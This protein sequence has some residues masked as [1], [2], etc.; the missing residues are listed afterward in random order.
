MN[1]QVL[2][3]L[4]L[5][6][7]ILRQSGK[8]SAATGAGGAEIQV[9][10][11]TNLLT[12]I[13]YRIGLPDLAAFS[14]LTPAEV[15]V[16]EDP[17]SRYIQMDDNDSRNTRYAK[18]GD[19]YLNG[20]WYFEVSEK[21]G[22]YRIRG[23]GDPSLVISMSPKEIKPDAEV[24]ADY[25]LTYGKDTGKN[26]SLW[27][28]IPSDNGLIYQLLNYGLPGLAK[29]TTRIGTF[30]RW[31]G[32]QSLTNNSLSADPLLDPTFFRFTLQAVDL[33]KSDFY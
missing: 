32:A 25:Y 2:F 15:T 28:I 7:V 13:H 17:S 10:P 29:T 21:V 5:T 12:G 11:G 1:S 26:Y 8:V 9:I 33:D 18:G 20:L 3:S 24:P 14:V 4:L 16:E 31:I 23:G 30:Y 27:Q 6:T 22:C 19:W